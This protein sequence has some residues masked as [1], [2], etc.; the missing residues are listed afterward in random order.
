MS[1]LPW[2]EKAKTRI[3]YLEQEVTKLQTQ[4]DEWA[5]ACAKLEKDRSILRSE[6]VFL[7]DDNLDLGEEIDRLQ[8]QALRLRR[9]LATARAGETAAQ[10]AVGRHIMKKFSGLMK[11]LAGRDTE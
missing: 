8:E 6:I 1:D 2:I 9:E 11:R 4:K 7:K 10:V 5:K 3:E